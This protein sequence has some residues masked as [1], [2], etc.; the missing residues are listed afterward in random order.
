MVNTLGIGTQKAMSVSFQFSS[1][2]TSSAALEAPVDAGMMFW[3]VP[4]PSC[5][6]FSEGP[7]TLFWVAMKAWIVV[8]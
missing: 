4:Q 2:V 3:A 1:G 8:K 5:H 7:S 6:S